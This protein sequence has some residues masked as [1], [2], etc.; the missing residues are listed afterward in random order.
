MTPHNSDRDTESRS[1]TAALRL[2]V[3]PGELA[4]WAAS[5]GAYLHDVW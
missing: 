1:G 2:L 4:Q 3:C 5:E